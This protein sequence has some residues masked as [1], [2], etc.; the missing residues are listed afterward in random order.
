MTT[1]EELGTKQHMRNLQKRDGRERQE[2]KV[3]ARSDLEAENETKG[4]GMRLG[5][6]NETKGLGMLD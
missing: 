6:G 4:L 3:L 5:F 1:S 2:E